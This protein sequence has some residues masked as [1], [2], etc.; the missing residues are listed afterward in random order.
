M[1]II[2]YDWAGVINVFVG[3]LLLTSNHP[4]V[5]SAGFFSM[6]W[7]NVF[8]FLYG[9]EVGSEALMISSAVFFFINFYGSIRNILYE[10]PV[11]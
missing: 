4:R 2:G 6:V 10:R 11:K 5:R 9:K 7:A 3:T 8:F 1:D